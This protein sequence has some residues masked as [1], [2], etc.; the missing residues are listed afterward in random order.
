MIAARSIMDPSLRA[1]RSNPAIV[2][3][4][5]MRR[6]A[7]PLFALALGCASKSG[8]LDLWVASLRSQ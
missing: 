5:D 6:G 8:R 4:A 3:V 1:E 2:T 7:L